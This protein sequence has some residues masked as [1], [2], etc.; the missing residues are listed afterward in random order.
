MDILNFDFSDLEDFGELESYFPNLIDDDFNLD[1]SDIS[2]E[3][4]ETETSYD[5]CVSNL[6]KRQRCTDVQILQRKYKLARPRIIKSDFRRRFPQILASVFNSTDYDFLRSHISAFYD[7]DVT[8][9]QQDLR[10]GIRK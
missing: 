9:L 3:S 4:A 10:S 6:P 5:D 1:V 7:N 8:I 2:V